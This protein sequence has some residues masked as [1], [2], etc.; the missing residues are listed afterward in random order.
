MVVAGIPGA[1]KSTTLRGLSETD[2]PGGVRIVDSESVRRSLQS[3]LPGVPYLFL[4]PLVHTVHWVRIAVLAV[5]ETRPLL[6]HETATRP[7]S[8]AALL[9]IA[10]LGHRP[11]RLVWIEV[12][13]EI[14]QRGQ[15]TRARVVRAR[16]FRRHVRRINHRHPAEAAARNWD[17]VDRTDR[18]GARSAVIAAVSGPRVDRA[19]ATQPG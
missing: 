18:A 7:V 15:L 13:P 14:A 17:S 5:A 9:A 19:D 11:A 8:R 3:K 4:R 1:G 6:I 2:L 10:R 16:A 12:P